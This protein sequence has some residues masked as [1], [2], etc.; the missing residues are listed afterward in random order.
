MVLVVKIRLIFLHVL[1][2]LYDQFRSYEFSNLHFASWFDGKL[3]SGKCALHFL[4]RAMYWYFH[5]SRLSLPWTHGGSRKSGLTKLTLRREATSFRFLK[6]CRIRLWIILANRFEII[7]HFVKFNMIKYLNIWIL[8]NTS[9]L[10]E[11]IPSTELS[12]NIFSP[13]AIRLY[14]CKRR[15]NTP[16][17]FKNL[18]A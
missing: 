3:Y 15:C 6:L 18:F 13:F 7:L 4:R 1:H 14:F 2:N 12:S 5:D 8:P 9:I 17:S 11:E 10:S 16:M